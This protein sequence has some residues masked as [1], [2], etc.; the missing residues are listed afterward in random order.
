MD[1]SGGADEE[2]ILVGPIPEPATIM[3]L[4]AGAVGAVLR[5]RPVT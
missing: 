4:A 1:S 3:L 5:R 2:L